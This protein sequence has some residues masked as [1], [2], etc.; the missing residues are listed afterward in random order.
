M[1]SYSYELYDGKR[2]PPLQLY[3][4]QGEAGARTFE[5]S[6]LT[7]QGPSPSLT[8]TTVYAYVLKNDGT[9]VVIDCQASSNEVTFTLPLQ[10]CTCPG[11]NKMAIQAVTGTTDLRWDNLLLYVEPC[12]LENAVASTDDLGPIANIIT[13]PDYLQTI[14]NAYENATDALEDLMGDFK[15]VGDWNANTAYKTLNIVSHEGYSYA[16]NQNSTGIKPPNATYWTLIGSKGDQGTQGP[17]GEQ[18]EP[19]TPG[20]AATIQIGQVTTGE[21]DTSASVENTGTENAAVLKFTIPRGETG[22]QGIQGPP[23]PQGSP[24]TGLDILGTYDT[25]EALKAAV[26]QP[27]QGQMY[28][29]GTSD[30][31]TVYMWDTTNGGEWLS[32]GQLQGAKGD[33][34]DTG[35]QGQPGQAATV[36]VGQ[37]TTGEPGSN[38]TVTNSGT[39]N[40]A[41]LDF[42]IPRGATGAKGDIGATPDLTIG[43]VETL[44]PG[45]QATASITGTAE[46]PVLNLG[47]PKGDTGEA[48]QGGLTAAAVIAL[49]YPVGAIM[50]TTS[51]VNPGTYLTGTTWESFGAGKTLVGVDTADNDFNIAAK[52]GGAKTA[53]SQHNHSTM[54]HTLTL[55]E[56]P[57]H[58]HD[59]SHGHTNNIDVATSGSYH[60][61]SISIT[62]SSNGP[63]G[64]I[65]T[66]GWKTASANNDFDMS[67]PWFDQKSPGAGSD[68]GTVSFRIN[69]KHTHTVSGNTSNG[70]SHTHELSGTVGNYNGDT[71]TAGGGGSHNHGETGY[72]N[73]DTSTVQPYI[74]CYF[75]RRTA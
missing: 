33:T 12:E 39:S 53:S 64:G 62:T 75:W 45:Q 51:N 10:A 22:A 73:V 70:G 55:A 29:V 36:Q 28:N 68:F 25:L 31:Y 56:I 65:R 32:Q 57:S 24:G 66:M 27:K 48:G 4:M 5:I 63:T 9:V 23:G 35:P 60:S 44:S 11:V 30:P 3:A 7:D 46:N 54:S 17:P 59:M 47:I 8:G 42:S 69:G 74:T 15:P 26:T 58:D 13:D 40:A 71:D 61:H 43:E 1:L 67:D 38:A 21:P 37:V 14:V 34:G 6:L 49:I 20:K 18:G 16:A 50:P 52:T 2:R 19:G 41:V 72:T